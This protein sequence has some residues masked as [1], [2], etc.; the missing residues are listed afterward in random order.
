VSISAQ[1]FLAP[2]SAAIFRLDLPSF[3]F[4]LIRIPSRLDSAGKSV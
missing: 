3:I 4:I 2:V 1:E